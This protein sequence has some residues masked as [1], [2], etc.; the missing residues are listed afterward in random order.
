MKVSVVAPDLSGGGGTRAYLIARVLESLNYQVSVTGFRFGDSLYP[1]PPDDLDVRWVSGD[2][3]PQFFQS[4]T[5]LLAQLDGDFIYA[6]KPRLTSFG[7]SLFKRKLSRKPVILDIDDWEM[8][9]FGGERWQYRPTPRQL[10]RDLLKSNGALRDPQHPFYIR[11]SEKWVKW[12]DAI[13]ADTHFLQARYGGTYLPNGKDT[14]LFD[15]KCFDSEECRQKLQLSERKVLMF[16]GTARPHKGLEDV[17]EALDILDCEDFRLVIVGG[18]QIGDGYLEKLQSRWSRWIVKLPS[19]PIEQ[20][21]SVVAAAHAIVVPQRD[22]ITSRAQFPIKLTDGMSMAKPILA[23]RVGDIP[24]ILQDTG[25]LVE[26][27]N[28]QAIAETIQQIFDRLDLAEARGRQ[29]RQRCIEY[30]SLQAMAS[31]LSK[32]TLSLIER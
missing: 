13:T 15:P 30:Y 21:P 31:I 29:A 5:K 4:A 20:M 27:Q 2:R 14:D 6:I 23:T 22:S 16:P 7:I 9:W 25:Y 11:Q 1:L 3:F 32:T 17:L 28:P 24:K 19:V 8:S 18:R 10:A 12:A 26:P